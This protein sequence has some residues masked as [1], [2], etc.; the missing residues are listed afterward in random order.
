ME[1]NERLA[2]DFYKKLTLNIKALFGKK[3]DYN[4]L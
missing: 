4:N 1:Q 3:W 2:S